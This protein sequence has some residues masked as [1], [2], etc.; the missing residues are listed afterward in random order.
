[1]A[2]CEPSAWEHP[3][4]IQTYSPRRAVYVLPT[5]DFGIFTIGRL[6]RDPTQRQALE[7]R[8][9]RACRELAAQPRPARRLPGHRDVCAT[10]RFEVRWTTSELH[11]Y[12]Q[13]RDCRQDK[14]PR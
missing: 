9:E 7:D 4:L 14:H 10:G 6:P 1:V 13:R 2:A 3:R 11:P 12:R 5:E 8:A